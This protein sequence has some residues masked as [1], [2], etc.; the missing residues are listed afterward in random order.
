MPDRLPSLVLLVGCWVPSMIAGRAAAALVRRHVGQ[1]RPV[2][3]HGG[4][5]AFVAASSTT[6]FV[7]NLNAVPPYIPGATLDPTFVPPGAASA[8]ALVTA[9]VVLPLSA[10]AC[11]V[12]YRMGMRT[13]DELPAR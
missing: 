5:T 8:L 9:V 6:W 13:S 11:A 2:L 3:I 4:L 10:I 1:I 7:I 12:S